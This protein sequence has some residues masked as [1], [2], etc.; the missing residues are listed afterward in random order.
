[1]SSSENP[2]PEVAPP[3]AAAHPYE[4]A[5]PEEPAR[6]GP[7]SRLTGT[8]LSPGET[9][10]DVNRKPT[11]LAPM[12]I[13]IATVIAGS[14]FFS[15]RVKP[16]WDQVI[17]TQIKKQVDRSGQ[18][19]TEEQMQQRVNIGK[20]IAKFIPIIGAVFTPIVFLAVAGVFA[21]GLMFIQAK[22][23]F[24]KIL[25]VV[26]WSWAATALVQT[27]VTMAALMI[28]DEESLRSLDPSQ[29]GAIVPTNVAAFLSSETSG[30]IKSIAGSLDV[31]SI[32]FLILLSIGFAAIA[33]SRK[34]TAGKTA[35]V[36]FGFWIVV[37]LI[38]VGWAAVTGG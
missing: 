8:L 25:S 18:T 16:D 30:V 28:R 20:T 22:A 2:T 36:V 32:W 13:A 29:P 33:G 4:Q 3:Y 24:R 7:V 1:M 21:L 6:L 12:I 27:I 17:R 31:F 5:P 9:F 38:K 26:A 23:T 15:W 19:L 10:A 37:V 35:T 34:I 14:L 11:W